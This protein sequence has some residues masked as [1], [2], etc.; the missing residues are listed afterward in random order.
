MF[1]S[2]KMD[3]SSTEIAPEDSECNP[4]SHSTRE[5]TLDPDYLP[6]FGEKNSQTSL[7]LH[8]Q[9]AKE[10]AV[11]KIKNIVRNQF[12]LEM[13]IKEQE[14]ETIDSNIRQTKVALDRIR[15]CVLARYYGMSEVYPSSHSATKPNRRSRREAGQFQN[16]RSA[17]KNR[18][19]SASSSAISGSS[20]NFLKQNHQFPSKDRQ[21]VELPKFNNANSFTVNFASCTTSEIQNPRSMLHSDNTDDCPQSSQIKHSKSVN[22]LPGNFTGSQRTQEPNESLNFKKLLESNQELNIYPA[23]SSNCLNSIESYT[24]VNQTTKNIA[25]EKNVLPSHSAGICNQS[26]AVGNHL[27]A[28]VN[29]TDTK[30]KVIGPQQSNLQ[31]RDLGQTQMNDSGSSKLSSPNIKQT[32][33]CGSGSRF[34]VK[35]RVIIGNTSKYI[36]PDRREANDKSTHKWMVYVRGP[37]QDPNIDAYIKKVWFFLHP[38]YRPNDIVEINKPPFHLTRRGWGEFPIRVQLHFIGSWNKRVDIIHELK[39]DKTYTGLQTLGTETVVDLEI[40]RKT[41]EDLG[42]PVPME[43]QAIE[44]Q[45]LFESRVKLSSNQSD[46][47]KWKQDCFLDGSTDNKDEESASNFQVCYFGDICHPKTYQIADFYP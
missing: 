26:S 7:K 39:L 24:D 23:K 44:D 19:S 47:S 36:P 6:A 45:G 8:Q 34:Y 12:A 11:K 27:S 13:R 17:A 33:T 2:A 43:P 30:V 32:D 40:D 22:L 41:F 29:L 31:M 15:A 1:F 42:I 46:V 21:K 28:S 35:K 4:E 37:P 3:S 10:N 25:I 16:R 20:L 18:I 5:E 38:S 9:D 14:I